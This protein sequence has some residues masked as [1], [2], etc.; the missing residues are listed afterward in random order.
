MRDLIE[1]E[2]LKMQK[3]VIIT[4]ILFT[5]SALYGVYSLITKLL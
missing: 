2:S 1:R 5:A 3:W 4:L